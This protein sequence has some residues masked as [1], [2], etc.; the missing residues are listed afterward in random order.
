[1]FSHYHILSY[2]WQALYLKKQISKRWALR[3]K[4]LTVFGRKKL[5]TLLYP[6]ST[7]STISTTVWHRIIPNCRFDVTDATLG[8][9]KLHNYD[10]TVPPLLPWHHFL[11]TS[12]YDVDAS[13]A[14]SAVLVHMMPPYRQLQWPRYLMP[15]F[16]LWCQIPYKPPS[17]MTS[18]YISQNIALTSN[19]SSALIITSF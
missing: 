16:L 15:I 6:S 11:L 3:G 19:C 2:F 12:N 7:M 8:P 10:V 5:V 14:L 17:T 1:M 13:P 4:H 9:P 18:K